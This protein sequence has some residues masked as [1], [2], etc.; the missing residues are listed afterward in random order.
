[1]NLRQNFSCKFLVTVSG[2]SF[3]YQFLWR[4]SPALVCVV[5]WHKYQR[6][7][8]TFRKSATRARLGTST[9]QL[10]KTKRPASSTLITLWST[11]VLNRFPKDQR[12]VMKLFTS[13]TLT[14]W[15]CKQCFCQCHTA[16]LLFVICS[17]LVLAYRLTGSYCIDDRDVRSVVV[18]VVM[19]HHQRRPKEATD[20]CVCVNSVT[21]LTCSSHIAL[22]RQF[23]RMWIKKI[24]PAVFWKFFQDGCEFLISFLCTYYTILS[25][26]DYKFLFKYLQLWQ[27]YA[28]LST[29]T[30]RI[31]TFH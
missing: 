4:V 30:Q 5:S 12:S 21:D 10:T 7:H 24:P 17:Q 18:S 2:T 14:Q 28:I 1:M 20:V 3:W 29:T 26:L 11:W 8:V 15:Q 19:K 6:W 27:S 25:T 23:V 13:L 31:F 9:W 16:W 22:A